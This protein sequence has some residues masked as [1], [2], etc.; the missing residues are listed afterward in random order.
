MN[1]RIVIVTLI[2]VTTVGIVF[3]QAPKPKPAVKSSSNVE[4]AVW[5]PGWESV[6][7]IT[8]S[9]FQT[10]GID[11]KS[12]EQATEIFN[13]LMTNR[14]AFI[15]GKYYKDADE[16]KRV[17]VFVESGPTTDGE[18]SGGSMRTQEFIGQLRSRL[19]AIHDVSLVYSEP[20]ADIVIKTLT[21]PIERGD[22][23]TGFITSLVLFEP[24]TFKS[25]SGYD[26]GEQ[27]ILKLSDHLLLSGPTEENVLSRAS[28][29]IDVS[30]LDDIR[31]EHASI[32]KL[33]NP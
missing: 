8:G 25:P 23:P 24:C 6:L 5:N 20:D 3:A 28:S 27:T 33:R 31:K 10:L 2:T 29:M 9:D 21:V 19:S 32:L 16:L 4:R 18:G 11:T 15:C 17:H 12:K 13:Y 7:G 22:V 26:K 30:D 1:R 14:P